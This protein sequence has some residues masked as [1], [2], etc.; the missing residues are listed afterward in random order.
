MARVPARLALVGLGHSFREG[1]LRWEL[2]SLWAYRPRAPGSFNAKASN[3]QL[4]EPWS[5][6]PT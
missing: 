1:L 4:R 2:G 3:R 6:R 5:L